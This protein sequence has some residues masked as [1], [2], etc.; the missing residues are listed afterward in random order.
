VFEEEFNRSPDFASFY[1]IRKTK[2]G[3]ITMIALSDDEFRA[4]CRAIGRPEIAEDPRFRTIMDRMQ[5]A[6]VM[7]DMISEVVAGYATAEITARLEAEDVPHAK[8]LKREEVL[9]NEQVLVNGSIG[10]LEDPHASTARPCLFAV[11]HRALESTPTKCWVSLEKRPI[12]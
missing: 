12:R 5:N 4:T 2:D 11:P 8:V 10:V 9:T 1:S 3:Y 6:K 7:T